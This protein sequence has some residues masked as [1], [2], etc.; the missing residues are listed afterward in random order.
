[1]RGLCSGEGLKTSEMVKC[2]IS[3]EESRVKAHR[4][5]NP[6]Y[7]YH[8]H[9]QCGWWRAW[10]C[11]YSW[12]VFKTKFPCLELTVWQELCP[13]AR[14]IPSCW[15]IKFNFIP[16]IYHLVGARQHR[17]RPIQFSSGSP[18]RIRWLS[19]GY[20]WASHERLAYWEKWK[21]IFVMPKMEELRAV[22]WFLKSQTREI[23]HIKQNQSVF[24][25]PFHRSLSTD[26]TN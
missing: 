24:T 15:V 16:P 19:L 14:I 4:E 20:A 17:I 21:A 3:R 5:W 2:W 9:A 7:L 22:F 10:L 11:I 12:G 18:C 6:S 23:S 13:K 1:M 26:V 25:A 8:G